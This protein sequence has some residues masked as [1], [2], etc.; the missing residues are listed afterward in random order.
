MAT[1]AIRGFEVYSNIELPIETN[2]IIL[3]DRGT[4]TWQ[5]HCA[6]ILDKY[7][8][9]PQ[10]LSVKVLLYPHIQCISQDSN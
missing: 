7:L 1:H 3:N 6:V 9:A 8:L 4:L 5:Y 10:A 2:F